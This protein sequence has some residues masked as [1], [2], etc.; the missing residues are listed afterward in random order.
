MRMSGTS[1]TL[2]PVLAA[3]LLATA[4]ACGSATEPSS[5]ERQPSGTPAPAPIP[6]PAT[7]MVPAS[8][9]G[10]PGVYRRDVVMSY[11]GT[12][13]VVLKWPDADY[14]LQLYVTSGACADVT[15][16]L[17]GACT[18]LGRTRPGELPGMVSR[19]VTTGDVATIWVLN[20]DPA[21]QVVT[22]VVEMDE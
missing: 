20:T 8:N 14:S 9:D 1:M 19:R 13:T 17:M 2:T 22:V 16:L 18:I 21:P 4:M 5:F 11:T 10:I 15:D 6:Q 3:M 12:A 7:N